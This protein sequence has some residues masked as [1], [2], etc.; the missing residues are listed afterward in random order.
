MKKIYLLKY[1]GLKMMIYLTKMK[2]KT[3]FNILRLE[4]EYICD[5]ED[6]EKSASWYI[7]SI[8]LRL[9][10][11]YIF[12]KDEN[13]P[14]DILMLGKVDIFDKDENHK[15]A[16]GYV[17]AWGGWYIQQ[18]WKLKIFLLIYWGLRIMIYLTKMKMMEMKNLPLDILRQPLEDRGGSSLPLRSRGLFPAKKKQMVLRFQPW[19]QF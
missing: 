4:D 18:R 8:L 3:L 15:S 14:P 19:E 10:E 11:V 12:N 7:D 1:W 9:E 6:N 2:T 17:E 16:S 13:L 5:K